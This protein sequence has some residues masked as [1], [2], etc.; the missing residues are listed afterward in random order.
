MLPVNYC[1]IW[2]SGFRGENFL[3]V[4]HSETKAFYCGHDGSFIPLVQLIAD[5]VEC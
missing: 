4:S 2:A 3:N 5:I 1:S